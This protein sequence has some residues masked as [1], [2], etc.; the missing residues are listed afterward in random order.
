[1]RLQ[2][3]MTASGV[4][5]SCSSVSRTSS[6]RFAYGCALERRILGP[7]ARFRYRSW[8]GWRPCKCCYA[9][10]CRGASRSETQHML[11]AARSG[12]CLNVLVVEDNDDLRDL[13][14]E[15]LRELG[16]EPVP[17]RDRASAM[18]TFGER[19]IDV[20]LTDVALPDGSGIALASAIS[21][22]I[23]ARADHHL[24]RIWVRTRWHA[25]RLGHPVRCAHVAEAF[26]HRAAAGHPG[27]G[28]GTA[29]PLTR[30]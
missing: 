15:N 1:M 26:R 12:S 30:V 8:A 2:P 23:S 16:H 7:G 24:V 4:R 6:A 9:P 11:P 3:V 19:P 20:L 21:A 17:A 25:H 29:R 28:A 5:N 27:Q 22:A 10:S 18:R 14:A 13:I